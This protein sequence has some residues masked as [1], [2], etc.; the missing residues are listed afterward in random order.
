MAADPDARRCS[1]SAS[2]ART[3]ACA[4]RC[5]G[6]VAG[7]VAMVPEGLVL[8]TSAS[9]SRSASSA[10]PDAAC[11]CRS[12]R[13]SRC[14]R[15][16]TSCA[17]TRPA[18]SPRAASSST[19]SSCSARTD[20]TAT[21]SPRSPPPNPT[22]TRRCSRSARAFPDPRDGWLAARTVPFSSARK[23]SG[24]DFGTRGTWVLGA[25]DVLLGSRPGDDARL[26]KARTH[27]EAGRRVVLLGR[28]DAADRGRRRPDRA[29]ARSPSCPDRPGPRDAPRRRSR[30]SP[31]RAWTSRSSAAT[32]PRPWPRSPGASV[33]RAPR[34]PFD[35]KALPEGGRG[36]RRRA[37]DARRSSDGSPRSRSGR[38]SR[39]SSRAGTSSR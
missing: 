22:R 20:R 26:A 32:T 4:T 37:R 1:W 28:T 29:R 25:P 8:L 24:A 6:A 31:G 18:R 38:W 39:R 33:S 36:A 13:R 14:S 30:T 35:A 19:R 12:C 9:P 17:S 15:A 5:S 16:S 2:S 7:T 27:A 11:S 10:W 23:W 3:R 34:P 21:R